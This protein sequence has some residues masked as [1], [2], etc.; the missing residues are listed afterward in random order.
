[1]DIVD[2]SNLS[3][4]MYAWLHNVDKNKFNFQVFFLELSYSRISKKLV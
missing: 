1:M 3:E 4:L 2:H